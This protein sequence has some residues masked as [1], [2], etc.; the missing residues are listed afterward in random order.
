MDLK[1]LKDFTPTTIKDTSN[2]PEAINRKT[3]E[4]HLED[5]PHN[6]STWED[7]H[8]NK[9]VSSATETAANLSHSN[10]ECDEGT[11]PEAT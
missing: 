6:V 11:T 3:T 4:F 5:N 2:N 8:S 9:Q 7:S 1:H 10:M